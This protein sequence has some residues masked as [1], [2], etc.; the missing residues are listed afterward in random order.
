MRDQRWVA[1]HRGGPLKLVQHRQLMEWAC[2]CA[3]HVL[4]L[5]GQPIDPR[6]S[7][8]LIVARKWAGGEVTVGQARAASVAVQRIVSNLMSVLVKNF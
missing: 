3:E 4:P 1:Q 5:F 2:L 6:L 7:Q 8:A